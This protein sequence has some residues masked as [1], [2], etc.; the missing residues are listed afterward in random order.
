MLT[1]VL[2][3]VTSLV[4]TRFLLTALFPLIALV[5][6]CIWVTQLSGQSVLT[7]LQQ[8]WSDWSVIEQFVVAVSSI[9]VLFVA[10]Y[11]IYLSS[12]LRIRLLEG[13]YGPVAWLGDALGWGRSGDWDTDPF[14]YRNYPRDVADRFPSRLGNSIR[15]AELYPYEAYRFDVV[16]LWP[17]LT[18]AV[19]ADA[20]KPLDAART[21]L[22]FLVTI[23]LGGFLYAGYAGAYIAINHGG[24]L[25]WLAM[26]LAGLGVG[27]IAYQGAVAAARDYGDQIRALV[28][29][30]R[31]ALRSAM[32]L[33]KPQGPAEERRLW[34]EVST[35]AKAGEPA[36]WWTYDSK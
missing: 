21:S 9:A 1:T 13:Y 26:V 2:D 29:V 20:R 10:A 17:S 28:D 22:D 35:Q 6:A 33:P 24:R 14:G 16:Y 23:C 5:A 8:S 27:F 12:T 30:H 32:Q 34:A 19:D 36:L 7:D 15:A 18:A 31:S 25:L 4:D 11:L 3:K